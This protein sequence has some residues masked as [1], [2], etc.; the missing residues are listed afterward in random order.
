M[1]LSPSQLHILQHSL[2]L[3]RYGR[4]REYRNSFVTGHGSKDF[5]GCQ[6]LVAG[7]CMVNH[8]DRKLFS[9]HCFSV[10]DWGRLKMHEQSPRPPRLTRAQKRW[11]EWID[12]ADVF[13][14]DFRAWL[15]YK[16]DRKKEF[17][18]AY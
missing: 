1:K 12:V 15:R 17:G 16:Q 7:G 3:D 5:E 8:G 11:Q 18:E 14:G 2:G 9:G 10:T 4:G 13:C 6:A